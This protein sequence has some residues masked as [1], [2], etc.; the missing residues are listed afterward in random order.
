MDH[1]AAGTT[2]VVLF[3]VSLKEWLLTSE[4][5][6]E[7]ESHTVWAGVDGLE[8]RWQVLMQ[9]LSISSLRTGFFLSYFLFLSFWGV[10]VFQ[11]SAK[12]KMRR[13]QQENT[14]GSNYIQDWKHQ[15]ACWMDIRV[16]DFSRAASTLESRRVSKCLCKCGMKCFS[17]R[18]GNGQVSHLYLEYL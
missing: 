1:N 3:F 12:Y 7:R 15:L 2:D 13:G 17:G 6:R 14:H 18:K 16:R 4:K 9:S 5:E 10:C 11:S 8:E